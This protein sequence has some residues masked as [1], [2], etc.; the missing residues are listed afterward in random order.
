MT[1][2]VR[3]KKFDETITKAASTIQEGKVYVERGKFV[4]KEWF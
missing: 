4:Q 1:E 3:N 2:L